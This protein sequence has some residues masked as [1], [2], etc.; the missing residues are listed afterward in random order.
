L[1]AEILQ[2]CLRKPRP[3]ASRAY[4][5]QD[6]LLRSKDD[7]EEPRERI[8]IL[9][10][11]KNIYIYKIYFMYIYIYIYL[12]L[13]VY[14]F[15]YIYVYLFIYTYIYIYLCILNKCIQNIYVYTSM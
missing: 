14:L 3:P 5:Y 8:F 12:Y 2:C 13:Y 9:N 4:M 15:L 10:K 6:A 7:K 1:K 11:Q